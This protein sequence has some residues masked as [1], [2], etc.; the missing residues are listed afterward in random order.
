MSVHFTEA[1]MAR[2]VEIYKDY[3]CLWDMKHEYYKDRDARQAA[4]NEIAEKLNIPNLNSKDIPNKI[5]NLRSSYYQEIKK[6]RRSVRLGGSIYHPKVS[7]FPTV[8]SIL[9]PFRHERE[10]ISKRPLKGTENIDRF[11]KHEP[12]RVQREIK[13]INQVAERITTPN[14]TNKPED[15][16]DSF[17]K[18][19]A[20]SLRSMPQEFSIIAKTE[21][22]KA[23]SN[24]QLKILRQKNPGNGHRSQ[25]PSCSASTY[26]EHEIERAEC[27]SP[28]SDSCVSTIKIEFNED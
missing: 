28:T 7:W 20:S 16:F 9:K 6:V 18:Y 11:I 5:K 8:D 26:S 25:S 17:G 23:I 10:F 21:L 19:I 1:D 24:I 14:N 22:Q 2:L 15:E 4:Y 3:D 12:K 27:M 13:Q